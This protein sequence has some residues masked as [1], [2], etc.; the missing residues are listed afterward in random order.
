[1]NETFGFSN[2]IL[3]WQIQVIEPG[4]SVPAPDQLRTL[5][6]F[7]PAAR[8]ALAGMA[9]GT[10]LT[11]GVE[12]HADGAITGATLPPGFAEA[13][14]E[15]GLQLRV[16]LV[17]DGYDRRHVDFGKIHGVQEDDLQLLVQALGLHEGARVLDLG[18]GYREVSASILAEA[19]RRQNGGRPGCCRLTNDPKPL[20]ASG[21]Q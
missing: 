21:L 9:P 11:L 4:S 13:A 10:K 7:G 1:M 18:C 2:M 16:E 15:A 6:S 8:R 17:A 5:L 19:H 20:V 3:D 14:K 12:I